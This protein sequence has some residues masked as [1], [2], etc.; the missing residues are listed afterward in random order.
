MLGEIIKK[1]G[2]TKFCLSCNYSCTLYFLVDILLVN[3]KNPYTS[4][5]LNVN[6]STEKHSSKMVEFI[7]TCD[8]YPHKFNFGQFEISSE[9]VPGDLNLKFRPK[10][11]HEVNNH[12][13][14]HYAIIK[15]LSLF[16]ET[17]AQEA[18]DCQFLF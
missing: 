13:C 11:N 1:W 5:Y 16:K 7:K 9:T 10:F 18:R 15:A 3:L 17:R 8:Q 14:L 12:D 6:Y 2:R 4:A